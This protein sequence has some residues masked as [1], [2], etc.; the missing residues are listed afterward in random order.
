MKRKASLTKTRKKLLAK[1]NKFRH[2]IA[3]NLSKV[4]APKGSKIFFYRLTWKE[5]QKTKIV[6]IRNEKVIEVKKWK[7]EE[8]VNYI[9]D[10]Q[11]ENIITDVID[12]AGLTDIL[13][14]DFRTTFITNAGA[15]GVDC[16]RPAHSGCGSPP[17]WRR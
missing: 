8:E 13:P 15:R 1:V 10:K 9:T 7:E 14:H 5:N 2:A 3:G 6:Y 4:E 17:R 16:C 11:V 12:R